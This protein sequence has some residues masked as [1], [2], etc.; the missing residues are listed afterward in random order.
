MFSTYPTGLGFGITYTTA[1]VSMGHYFD[2]YRNL[3]FGIVSCGC[4]IGVMF[5]SPLLAFLLQRYDW[6]GAVLIISAILA[7]LFVC[8]GLMRPVNHTEKEVK[9]DETKAECDKYDE[10]NIH[11]INSNECENKTDATAQLSVTYS[12]GK[13]VYNEETKETTYLEIAN[14]NGS[15]QPTNETDKEVEA[16]ED[17]ESLQYS[18]EKTPICRIWQTWSR[19]LLN[20]PLCSIN[21]VGFLIN[22]CLQSIGVASTYNHFPAF[23]SQIST[24]ETMLLT[25]IGLANVIGRPIYGAL[26]NRFSSHLV[27]IYNL[28]AVAAGVSIMCIPVLCSSTAGQIASAIAFAIFGNSFIPLMA[29]MSVHYVGLEHLDLFYGIACFVCGFGY[30]F[31]PVIAGK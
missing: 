2:K 8:A 3:A 4:G 12:E 28:S 13:P 30:I 23:I 29:P 9:Q 21:V 24:S 16:F 11:M 7:N 20:S 5:F 14:M 19:K 31:G 25:L 18:D 1:V 22:L 27:T 26:A 17:Q 10:N 15:S 6:R